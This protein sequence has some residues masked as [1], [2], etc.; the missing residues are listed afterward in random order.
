MRLVE[1]ASSSF[2]HELWNFNF[3]VV[4]EHDILIENYNIPKN[5]SYYV[6]TAQKQ[7][8]ITKRFQP[9][10]SQNPGRAKLLSNPGRQH[11][12]QLPSQTAGTPRL[13]PTTPLKQQK[14]ELAIT[15][16]LSYDE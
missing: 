5:N 11:P 9:S 6:Q 8:I 12:G 10:K 4:A 14:A 16:A 3:V 2:L 7:K 15:D 1:L 13:W